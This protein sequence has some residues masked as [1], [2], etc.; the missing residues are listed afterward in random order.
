MKTMAVVFVKVYITESSGVLN[1]IVK[2]LK[3]EVDIRGLSVFRAT[4]GFGE[5]GEHNMSLLDLSLDLPLVVEFFDSKDKVQ[6][7][8]EYLYKNIKHEHIVTWD[9]KSNN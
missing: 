4:S 7:A 1:Q 2:Y 6:P 3:E 9:A 8:L 5:S